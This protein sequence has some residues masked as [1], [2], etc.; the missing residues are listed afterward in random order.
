MPYHPNHI[1]KGVVTKA[2]VMRKTVT[3]TVER[4]FEHP[5]I[6][7]EIK[8]HKKYLVH[9]EGEVA[10]VD[11]KVTIIHGPRTSKTKSF[12]LQSIDGRDTRKYPDDPIPQI[13]SEPHIRL[14]KQKKMGVLEALNEVRSE[15]AKVASP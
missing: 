7:K 13:I 5:K 6:L 10:K 14:R 15:G 2:G 3:V 11:D 9:D 8:R 1:F 12:R 4:I